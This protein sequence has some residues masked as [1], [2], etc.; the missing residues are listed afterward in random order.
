[1][2]Q[3]ESGR[4]SVVIPARNEQDS[5]AATIDQFQQ[6]SVHE[7]IVADGDSHDRTREIASDCGAAVIRSAPGRGR[8]QNLGAAAA[9]GDILLFLHA[10]TVLPPGFQRHVREVL[11]RDGVSAGAFLLRIGAPRRA[12]RLVERMANW[13]SNILQLPYGDQALFVK[14]ETFRRVGGF[15]DIPLM[16][17][18]ELM[19]RLRQLGR[20]EIAPVAVTTSARRWDHLG[21]WRATWTNQ[22][23]VFAY[24]LRISPRRIARWRDAKISLGSSVVPPR[25]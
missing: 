8:Q 20:I 2:S 13:R 11:A 10:D 12:L 16:E 23:C 15:P 14:A 19:R 4:I 25:R 21:V 9:T 18:F 22:V 24:L 1:M 5:I 7:V 17:D 6:A 3:P